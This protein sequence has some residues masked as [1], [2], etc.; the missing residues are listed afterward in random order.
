VKVL[1]AI[2]E[3]KFSQAAAQ[4]V[5]ERVL[6]K[7][8]EVRVLHV[9]TP[10]SP[11]VGEMGTGITDTSA[12]EQAQLTQAK[13]LV[14]EVAQRLRAARLNVSTVVEEGDPKTKIIDHAAYWHADLIVLGSHGRKG[15]DRFLLGSVSEAVARHAPC[16]VEIVRFPA[17]TEVVERAA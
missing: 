12:W 15:I 13:T 14:D 5:I 4:A 11:V 1:L 10:I 7:D 3:S 2:D 8:T 9:V 17:Q 6:P 16:S